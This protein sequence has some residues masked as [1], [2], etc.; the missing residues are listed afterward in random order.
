MDL[1]TEFVG[2]INNLN[3]DLEGES[4]NFY[5]GYVHNGNYYDIRD[6]QSEND[7]DDVKGTNNTFKVVKNAGENNYTLEFEFTVDG[8]LLKGYY[9]VNFIKKQI[10]LTGE[11]SIKKLSRSA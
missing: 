2:S 1:P 7:G 10:I 9:S 11:H 8:K 5:C 4:W 3:A 6:N